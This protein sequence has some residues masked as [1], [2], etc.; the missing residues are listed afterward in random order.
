MLFTLCRAGS[1]ESRPTSWHYLWLVGLTLRT[2]GPCPEC[3]LPYDCRGPCPP[4]HAQSLP[5]V[6]PPATPALDIKFLPPNGCPCLTSC[7]SVPES[8][9]QEA[10]CVAPAHHLGGAPSLGSVVLQH[11]VHIQA[12]HGAALLLL[13]TVLSSTGLSASRGRSFAFQ[14]SSSRDTPTLTP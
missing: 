1:P 4:C 12:P 14:I 11:R 13:G 8:F 2:A 10:A 7:L 9:F 5:G 3:E 6:L